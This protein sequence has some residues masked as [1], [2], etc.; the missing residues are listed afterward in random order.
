MISVGGKMNNLT[1]SRWERAGGPVQLICRGGLS[2]S[3]LQTLVASLGN[4]KKENWP[5]EQL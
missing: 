3:T 4:L 1:Q 2:C 5:R